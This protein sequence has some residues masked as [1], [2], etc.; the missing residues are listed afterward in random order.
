[1]TGSKTGK[2]KT[3]VIGVGHLGDYHAQKYFN[4]PGVELAGVVDILPSRAEEIGYKYQTDAYQD[5]RD[6]LGRVDA[7]SVA[8]PTELHYRVGKDVLEAG[9]HLLMEKPITYDTAHAD[10][11]IDMARCR[12]LV[13]QVGHVERFNPAVVMLESLTK[14]PV[15]IESQ[16]LHLFTTRGTDVDVVL[17]LMIHDLDIILHLVG[18]PIKALNAVGMSVV[19]GKTDI[20][21][22]R[23]IFE[24]GTVAS[25]TASRVSG[26][27]VRKI[28]VFQPNDYLSADCLKRELTVAP[29]M[30]SGAAGDG[31]QSIRSSKTKFPGSDPLADQIGAFVNSV[32]MGTKPVVTGEDGR[33]AL[34]AALE[35]MN[36]INSRCTTFESFC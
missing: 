16:R 32:R 28:R 24:N 8:V 12:G 23:L 13:L 14:K 25:L 35:V 21:N 5:Y 1:M 22:V 36:L 9:V 15:F 34:R 2:I 11:L 33:D 7:V 20:G 27:T 19:T 3:A 6:V 17:D 10:T 18:S 4:H 26:T 30:P 29:L 31:H